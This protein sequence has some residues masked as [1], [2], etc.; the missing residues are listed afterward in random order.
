M[1]ENLDSRFIYK[2]GSIYSS[3]PA[4]ITII[5]NNISLY[6]SNL[7]LSNSWTISYSVII[8][9]SVIPGMFLM[10]S[11]TNHIQ[12]PLLMNLAKLLGLLQIFKT[13]LLMEEFGIIFQ[14]LFIPYLLFS[15]QFKLLKHV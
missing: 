12:E 9:I 3:L 1:A 6:I 11:Q 13:A 7:S 8:D 4:E 5:S 10:W 2:N 14:L 15:H